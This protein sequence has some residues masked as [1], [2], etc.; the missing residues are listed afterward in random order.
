[1]HIKNAGCTWL[2]L[3][4]TAA[5]LVW[6]LCVLF[7]FTLIFMYLGVRCLSLHI[8]LNHIAAL[9]LS[10]FLWCSYDDG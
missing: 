1:M 10:S 8:L 3:F 6:M 2:I 9:F 4:F 7:P 5:F